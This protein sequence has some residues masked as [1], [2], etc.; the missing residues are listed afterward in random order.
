MNMLRFPAPLVAIFILAS[1]C[2]RSGVDNDNCPPPQSRGAQYTVRIGVQDK[3]YTDV[4]ATDPS[5]AVDES[6][7]FRAYV[8][9]YHY[10]L[11]NEDGTVIRT[12]SI[13]PTGTTQTSD[14]VFT[15]LP[16]WRYTVTVWGN[17][18]SP[19]IL[20]SGSGEGSDT[21]LGK[22][23]FDVTD[24][25]QSSDLPLR[26]TKGLVKMVYTNLPA[27]I[28]QIQQE[29]GPVYSQVD[30]NSAYSGQATVTKTVPAA[31]AVAMYSAPPAT[32]LTAELTVRFFTASGGPV[33][34]ITLL[35][36]SKTLPPNG[37]A[38][39]EIDY[40]AITGS[41]EVWTTVDGQ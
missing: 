5:L 28:A 41:F 19:G 8:S 27:N 7:P 6:Q 15:D 11:S 17:T 16:Q 2:I 22:N 4:Q 31:G 14:L 38:L 30:G 39:I 34:S 37:L 32:G 9:S 24:T 25:P 35:P 36:V 18:S 23:T 12:A 13:S 20:H 3:N 26:R 1:S 33:P 40:N 21:Y 29:F 10:E